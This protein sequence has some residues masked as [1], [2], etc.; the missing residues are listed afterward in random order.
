MP[1]SS[2][3][4]PPPNPAPSQ[5]WA[6]SLLG[7]ERDWMRPH[8]SALERLLWIGPAMAGAA[9]DA[10]P[11]AL[12]VAM[13]GGILDGDLRASL[14]DWPLRDDCM[15]GVVI[16]HPLEAG[17]D[18]EPLLDEAMRVLKPECSLWLVASGTASMCRFRL[19]R[20][21]AA[22]ALWPSAFRFGAY[23][24]GMARRGAVDFELSPLAFDAEFGSLAAMTRSLPWAP[25]LLVHA[26]KRRSANILRPRA[27][28]SLPSAGV[29]AMPA[30]PASRVGLAA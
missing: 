25:V 14:I 13:Q 20:A 6:H 11:N 28:R 30:L 4:A 15:D 26:R 24:H 23:Q 18:I 19:A 3:N 9:A 7:A 2:H 16:Q 10:F 12:Q 29:P 5:R 1:A 17:L 22:G 8:L 21:L 27:L